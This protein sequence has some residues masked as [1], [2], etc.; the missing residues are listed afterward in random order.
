M[1]GRI[2][3]H[4]KSATLQPGDKV[5]LYTDGVTEAMNRQEEFFSD[6]RLAGLLQQS[7][8][9]SPKQLIEGIVG[10]VRRFSAGFAQNDDITVVALK[11]Q[12]V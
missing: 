2:P 10:E 3:Y 6:E 8:G 7:V 5:V 1:M 9:W 12:G 11:H 4:T